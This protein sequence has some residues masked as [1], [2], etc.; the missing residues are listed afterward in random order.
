MKCHTI[1][2]PTKLLD[3]HEVGTGRP[4]KSRHHRKRGL[5]KNCSPKQWKKMPQICAGRRKK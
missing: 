3:Y 4:S 1:K 5:V 2:V